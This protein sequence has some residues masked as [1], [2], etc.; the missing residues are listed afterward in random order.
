MLKAA[1]VAALASGCTILGT[2]AGALTG[3]QIGL[4]EHT[5][6]DAVIGG[7]IGA[8]VDLA[9]IAVVLVAS[10]SNTVGGR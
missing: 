8:A 5:G 9:V 2:S 1:L 10:H 6:R 3:S 7:A 4:G